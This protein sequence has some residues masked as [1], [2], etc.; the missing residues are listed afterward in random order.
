MGEVDPALST[1]SG[2]GHPGRR[3]LCWQLLRGLPGF[4]VLL[5]ACA[6]PP[7][8]PTAN[9]LPVAELRVVTPQG[10]VLHR[11]TAS[12]ARAAEKGLPTDLLQYHLAY[13][14]RLASPPLVAGNQVRLLIDGPATY[15]AMF[16]AISEAHDHINLETY[17]LDDDEVGRKLAALLAQKQAQGVQVNVLHDGAGTVDT[18]DGFFAEMAASGVQIHEFNPLVPFRGPTWGIN[19]RDHRKILVVDGKVAFTG[20]INISS[21]YSSGSASRKQQTPSTDEGWRDTQVEIRGPAVAQFQRLFIQSW[22]KQGG[23]P[24]T[25]RNYFPATSK[26]GDKLV[27]VLASS[28]DLPANYIYAEL[29]SAITHAR[30]SVHLTMAYFVPDKA[31]LRALE[32]AARRGVDVQLILPGFSDF[33]AVFHAGRSHYEELLKAGVK[34]HERRDAFLHA[35]SAVVDGVW[36]FVGSA[37]I[38]MRSF[39]HN[40]E[41]IAV[42]L[43][44]TFGRE[45]EAMFAADLKRATPVDAK[46]WADRGV[47]LRMKEWMARMWEYWL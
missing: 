36:S 34:I 19:H 2:G 42:V 6:S 41:V 13:M 3:R 8:V 15:K 26:Q 37:N 10:D 7:E 12:V 35:K 32:D 47:G 4:A 17:I 40:D 24:L 27:R 43:G 33:W 9:P 29:L 5:T 16:Q 44:Q 14:E 22:T 18:S 1:R 31:T 45:M 46:T 25:P 23:P 21:V 30:Q 39:L 28:P 20:G 11:S 38:D